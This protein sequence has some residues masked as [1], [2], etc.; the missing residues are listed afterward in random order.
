MHL[1]P[2]GADAVRLAVD[3]VTTPPDTPA[4]LEL[5]CVA[6]GLVADTPA[7]ETDLTATRRL[8]VEWCAIVDAPDAGTRAQLLNDLLAASTAHPRLTDHAEGWHLHYRDDD[9]P[10]AGVLR[11]LVAPGTALHLVGRGMDRLG[12]CGLTDCDRV[13]ADTSRGGKQ[14]YCSPACANRDAVRRHRSRLAAKPR[15]RNQMA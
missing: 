13:Y 2:Y 12:R 4:D 6:A 8:L 1:N 9:L 14:R 5:R 3:L 7:T 11:A 10:L 15:S